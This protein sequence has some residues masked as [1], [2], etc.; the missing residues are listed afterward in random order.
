MKK[1]I[2]GSSHRI[3][4]L[5]LLM[6][7]NF[8][9]WA[10]PWISITGE[11]RTE[12]G[13]PVCAMVLANG[14]YMFS[15]GGSGA[16]SLNV[17]LDEKG[18]ITLFAFA[19]G[20]APFSATVGQNSFPLPVRTRI[21]EPG[22]PL[23]NMTRAVECS[24]SGWV[25]VHGTIDSV[26]GQPLCGMVLANG[27]HMFSCGASQGRYDLTVPLDNKDEVTLFGFADGFQ[28]FS[29]TFNGSKCD[30]DGDVLRDI[31]ERMP[32]NSWA[33]ISLNEIRDVFTPV[34]QRPTSASPGSNIDAWSGAAWDDKRRDLL[35]WGGDIGNEQGNETYIFHTKTGL[36]ERGALP[37]AIVR[38]DTQYTWTVDG[39]DV[40]PISGESWDNLVYLKGFDRL[41]IMG[42]AREGQTWWDE[43]LNPT[44][45]Y[46]WDPAK[47]DSTKVSGLTGSQVNPSLFPDVIG[48]EMWQ[49][50]DHMYEDRGLT[51]G[52]KATTDYIELPQGDGV[53]HVSSVGYLRLFSID[54]INPPVTSWTL[55]GRR[56]RTGHSGGPGAGVYDPKRN[57]FVRTVGQTLPG[58]PLFLWDINRADPLNSAEIVFP[59]FLGNDY[60]ATA[61]GYGIVYD[62]VLD[63]FALWGGNRDVWLLTPPEIVSA[64]G[65]R[66]KRVLPPGTAET[67]LVASNL[68]NALYGKWVYV[69]TGDQRAYIGVTN[70][71]TGAV[72]AYKPFA[73]REE[74]IAN[75]FSDLF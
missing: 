39:S 26:D 36:W 71:D 27:Q 56:P 46:L 57:A 42:M 65:W 47:A 11:V 8:P 70:G 58:G 68:A 73:S 23:I 63:L 4:P 69:E 66:A 35:I 7:A 6:L 21:A 18:Q 19:D 9:G 14:E 20:F 44:G 48:G 31:L 45:P 61:G 16:Y 37:S 60:L 13:I 2:F 40:T 67:T 72:F 64:A 33:K 22:S 59:E 54:S 10:A 5:W 17:P 30:A 62:P 52:I 28:P 34:D 74:A 49:N 32:P 1:R 75:G 43:D 3:Y 29:R 53:L 50:L 15:C 38:E 41:I 51:A 12:T 25:R 55:L 24:S